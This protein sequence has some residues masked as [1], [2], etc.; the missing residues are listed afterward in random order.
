M[1]RSRS[2]WQ[3]LNRK[4]NQ[5]FES[6]VM[7]GWCRSVQRFSN[8]IGSIHQACSSLR[9]IAWSSIRNWILNCNDVL[10]VE[11]LG[12]KPLGRATILTNALGPLSNNP[13]KCFVHENPSACVRN[14]FGPQQC[15]EIHRVDIRF[16]L[17][18][19]PRRQQTRA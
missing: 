10:N 5:P 19:F 16:V 11:T 4:P 9:W 7:F 3:V 2:H 17:R 18:Q 15:Y 1:P 13:F 6:F 12:K 14:R 8:S